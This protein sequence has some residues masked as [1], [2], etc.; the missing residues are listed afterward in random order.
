[1]QFRKNKIVKMSDLERRFS[2]DLSEENNL[3]S[4]GEFGIVRKV[5]DKLGKVYAGKF[6]KKMEFGYNFTLNDLRYFDRVATSRNHES[7]IAKKIY[8]FNPELVLKPEGVFAVEYRN[9]GFYFPAFV[10]RYDESLKPISIGD[11]NEIPF[12]KN[13]IEEGFF[14]WEDSEKKPNTLI[15]KEGKI[16]LIDF[17]H[18]SYRGIVNPCPHLREESDEKL[19]Y[20]FK[21]TSSYSQKILASFI[22]SSQ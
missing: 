16:K 14:F 21:K 22:E 3:I 9:L 7:W 10:S 5:R 17:G 4:W 6:P 11:I 20:F 13:L 18:W 1:M 12:I 19:K 15:S 8:E 2:F